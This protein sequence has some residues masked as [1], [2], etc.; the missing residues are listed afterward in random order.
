M[1]YN[2]FSAGIKSHKNSFNYHGFKSA[3]FI[4]IKDW[5]LAQKRNRK[6]VIK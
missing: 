3:V 2:T 5:A 6:T 4:T 1:A